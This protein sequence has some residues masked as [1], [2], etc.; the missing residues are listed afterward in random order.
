MEPKKQRIEDSYGFQVD[1]LK[2][3]VEE[4][5]PGKEFTY[6]E[7]RSFIHFRITYLGTEL[8]PA[9]DWAP[10]ELADKSDDELW[11]LIQHLS[12]GKL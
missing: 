10:S 8:V 11:T 9:R 12:N 5:A 1:R 7:T 3:L 6:D 4:R 2:R